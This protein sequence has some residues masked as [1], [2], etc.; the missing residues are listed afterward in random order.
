[1]I[2]F[3]SHSPNGPFKIGRTE[4]ERTLRQ[5]IKTLATG[6]PFPL[7]CYHK[8]N[9]EIDDAF[10]DDA[11]SERLFHL[12]F[13]KKRLSG[14]WFDITIRDI[15]RHCTNDNGSLSFEIETLRNRPSS[16]CQPVRVPEHAVDVWFH[17]NLD[18]LFEISE[19]VKAEIIEALG[20]DACNFFE[21]ETDE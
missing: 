5:R 11:M 8:T 15:Y 10:I 13:E 6:Y 4:S 16:H 17:S 14:E 12:K 3:V 7:K 20:E 21:L 19:A 1:M 2:Y 18:G 9:L